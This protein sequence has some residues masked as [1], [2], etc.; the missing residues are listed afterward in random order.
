MNALER[1]GFLEAGGRLECCSLAALADLRNFGSNSLLDLLCVV[2][3]AMAMLTTNTAT[4]VVKSRT[5]DATQRRAT[6]ER[7][8]RVIAA[9]ALGEH[10]A[11]TAGAVLELT[12]EIRP[13]EVE[14]AWQRT[15]Q[16]PLRDF[17][18]DL[19]QNYSPSHV[20]AQFLAELDDRENDVLRYRLLPL[21]AGAPLDELA[22]RHDLSRER[23]RQIETRVK[24]RLATLRNSP[25]GRLAVT[26]RHQIGAAIPADAED[27]AGL[28]ALLSDYNEPEVSKLLLLYLAGPYRSD[29]DWVLRLPSRASLDGTRQ[30]LL[31]AADGNGLVT[32]AD[33]SDILDK[34][35]IRRQWHDPWIS[36]LHCLR[37]IS[38]NYLRWDGTTL[39]RLE[40]LLRLRGEPATAEELLVELGDNLNPR[41][42]KYRLMDDPRFIRINKQSQFALPDWGFDEY[43][44]IADEIEQEIE[45]CGGYADADHLV[46]TISATYGVAETS[47]RA[48]LAA[49]MFIVSDSGRVRLRTSHDDKIPVDTNLT[50]AADCCWSPVGWRL[51]IQVDADLLRGS[52]RAIP[53]AFAGYIGVGPGSKIAIPGPGSAI[54]VSW[55]LSSIVGPS[56]G[57]LR[58]LALA[59]DASDGDLLFLRYIADAGRFAAKV[60]RASDIEAADGLS[61]LA[62]LHG[63]RPSSDDRETLTAVVHALGLELSEGDDPVSILDLALTRRRQDSWRELLPETKKTK[64]IDEVLQRLAKALG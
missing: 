58:S 16:F 7:D 64:S 63:L 6:T 13:H 59:L 17:A 2:E 44:G 19:A 31:D 24:G 4:K 61:R 51:R 50:D 62:L 5:I 15:V 55:P 46:R 18:D 47:V 38:G 20:M 23:I 53:A 49:P 34:A 28:T 37:P 10:K 32:R 56:I 36:R 30:A 43:T 22:R 39:D 29:N 12:R 42:L 26:L 48:Y 52:G 35:D 21:E 33:V 14:V 25:V 1:E 57:S 11:E 40:R 8:L 41:G 9:W 3:A 54:T 45:R 60:V 27:A